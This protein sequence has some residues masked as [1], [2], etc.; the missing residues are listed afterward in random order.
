MNCYKK[1][2]HNFYKYSYLK[3]VMVTKKSQGL[4]LN[5]IVI[6]LLVII[7]LVVLIGY[8]ITGFGKSANQTGDIQNA[9]SKCHESNEL[10]SSVYDL[11][12]YEITKTQPNKDT[13]KDVIDVVGIDNCWLIEK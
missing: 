8:F 6:A 11:D 2:I 13:L 5:T 3:F 1:V 12:K 4:P 9:Y 7:V 10:I